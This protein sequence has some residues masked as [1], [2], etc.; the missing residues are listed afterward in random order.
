ML[1]PSTGP[2]LAR[3]LVLDASAIITLAASRHMPDILRAVARPCAI[4]EPLEREA[5]YV[6][7]GGCGDDARELELIDLAPLLADGVLQIIHPDEVELSTFIDLTVRLGDGEALSVAVALQRGYTFVTD[8][9][10]AVNAIDGRV[11][12]L[13]SL[14]MIKYWL[15]RE[16]LPG[17]A[18]ATALANVRERGTY[19]PADDHPLRPWWDRHLA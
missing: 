12:V 7:R 19:L 10:V 17:T 14:E 6:R 18:R 8:D 11:P 15:D 13:S 16:R 3:L 5:L 2:N 9:R 4:V 1:V